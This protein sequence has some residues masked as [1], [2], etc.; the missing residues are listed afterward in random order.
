MK[1]LLIAQQLDGNKSKWGMQCY[2]DT[3]S[4]GKVKVAGSSHI[5]YFV[6][7]TWNPV[8]V[9]VDLNN[10]HAEIYIRNVIVAEWQWSKQFDGSESVLELEGLSFFAWN[11]E[12]RSPE[13]FVD[14]IIFSKLQAPPPPTNL[15]AELIGNNVKLTWNSP[16]GEEQ[17]LLYKVYRNG[18]VIAPLLTDTSYTDLD[19]YPGKYYYSVKAS[20]TS[21]L[22]NEAGPIE[23]IVAGGIERNF[24]LLEIA[25]GT[26]CTYCP[27]AAS[28]TTAILLQIQL[29]ITET[30]ITM[31]RVIRLLISTVV[32]RWLKAA[33]P[34]VCTLYI[35]LCMMIE[36]RCFHSFPLKWMFSRQDQEMFK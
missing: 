30:T 26:W 8:R 4:Q 12:Q 27:G 22:S 34:K 31:Y 23:V 10:D 21:G 20:Y 25:T 5:F 7:E 11:S 32:I 6:Y 35:F 36:F 9:I 17:P 24:V 16:D 28:T 19:V 2:L 13:F 33:Q 3:G 18:V 1:F 14:D 15:H 29:L